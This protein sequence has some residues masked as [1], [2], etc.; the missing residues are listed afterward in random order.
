M[1]NINLKINDQTL[2]IVDSYKYLGL[3]LDSKMSFQKHL[4]YISGHVNYKLRKLKEIRH[5]IKNPTAVTIFKS[6]IKPHLD[7]CDI[8]WDAAWP[9]FS[10][11]FFIEK[12]HIRVTP[13]LPVS[14]G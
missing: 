3:I 14:T 2:D 6:L 9:S 12:N 1:D 11:F 7:Y 13:G 5:N 10:F 4:Y 8:I